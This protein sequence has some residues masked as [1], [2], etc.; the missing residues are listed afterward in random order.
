MVAAQP[1]CPYSQCAADGLLLMPS[2]CGKY[3]NK[4]PDCRC[5]NGRVQGPGNVEAGQ[6]CANC[7][8]GGEDGR[9]S[10]VRETDD[11]ESG[12]GRDRLTMT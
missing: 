8:D 9:P 5:C 4:P 7:S 12:N 2:G 11:T 10:R 1:R 6:V 3:C